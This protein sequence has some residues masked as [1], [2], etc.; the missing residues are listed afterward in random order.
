MGHHSGD[1]TDCAFED[2]AS[3]QR[4]FLTVQLY[5]NDTFQGG[6]TTFI[7][8]RLV[9]IEPAPGTVVVFDHELYHRGGQVTEGVKYA[10]RLDVAY[11]LVPRGDPNKRDPL[12]ALRPLA[13]TAV[14]GNT[15][16][17][18]FAHVAV[19]ATAKGATLLPSAERRWGRRG[20]NGG[21]FYSE[22]K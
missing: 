16:N 14:G 19:E 8:D 6:R 4:S 22:V 9:P 11:G 3:G 12:V 18:V 21:G 7:S 5:L 20:D 13:A 17:D 10:V 1:H 15:C 2:A